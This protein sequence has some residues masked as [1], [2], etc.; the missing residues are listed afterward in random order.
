[1]AVGSRGRDSQDCFPSGFQSSFTDEFAA[2]CPFILLSVLENFHLDLRDGNFQ[3]GLER[4]VGGN[5]ALAGAAG[6]KE[7]MLKYDV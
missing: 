3:S 4:H 6:T 7:Q 5:V 1:M 2:S